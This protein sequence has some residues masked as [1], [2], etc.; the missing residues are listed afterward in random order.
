[1]SKLQNKVAVITGG[2]SGIGKATAQAFINEG[3]S[4]VIFGRNQQTMDQAVQELGPK[5]IGVQGDVANPDDLKNLFEVTKNTFGNIDILFV[6]AGVAPFVPFENA[7]EDHFDY[8]MNV[9]VKGAYFT[10]QYALSILNDD[11]SII[12]TSSVVN[13]TGFPNMSVYS[14]SKA[15]VRSFARTMSTE[16]VER[17]IRV[18]VISPGP[19]ETPLFDRTGLTQ[20]EIAGFSQMIQGQVPLKRFGKPEEIATAAVFLASSD[21][22]YVV[23]SE[24][25]VDGGMTQV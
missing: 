15:A 16:L 14:A 6:N 11:A 1:M 17:G 19:I 2:N 12:L 23:G 7:D 13:A 25:V 22:S 10:V 4:L 9:N 3:A 5:A 20:E 21:S 24:I 18:N 8:V